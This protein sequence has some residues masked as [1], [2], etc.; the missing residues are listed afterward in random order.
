MA[1]IQ[2]Y[3]HSSKAYMNFIQHLMEN[4]QSFGSILPSVIHA[5]L[6]KESMKVKLKLD[7]DSHWVLDFETEDDYTAFR[8]IYSDQ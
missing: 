8:L 5:A 2:V 6:A 3:C 4:K 1:M 7:H